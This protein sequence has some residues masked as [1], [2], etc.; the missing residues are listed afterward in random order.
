MVTF[1]SD[2]EHLFLE[3]N[4]AFPFNYL[5]RS[6]RDRAC[7]ARSGKPR[8]LLWRYRALRRQAQDLRTLRRQ[9]FARHARHTLPRFADVVFGSEPRLCKRQGMRCTSGT[10]RPAAAAG[11]PVLAPRKDRTG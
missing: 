10:D 4:R 11:V 2:S 5:A 8:V 3:R 9:L 7:A 1:A 6:L